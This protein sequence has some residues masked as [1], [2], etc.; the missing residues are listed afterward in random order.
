M[1]DAVIYEGG[2]GTG[3]TAFINDAAKTDGNETSALNILNFSPVIHP[4]LKIVEGNPNRV[5]LQGKIDVRSFQLTLIPKA[6]W[7]IIFK[8]KLDETKMPKITVTKKKEW[9][10]YPNGHIET[11]TQTVDSRY[12]K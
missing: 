8:P 7:K 2:G 5:F 4:V 11:D 6:E 10:E 1:K 9:V 12:I 3:L